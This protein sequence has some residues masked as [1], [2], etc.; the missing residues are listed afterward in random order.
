V[1]DESD[2]LHAAMRRRH[3]A[4]EE[5]SQIQKRLDEFVELD[6]LQLRRGAELFGIAGRLAQLLRDEMDL[7]QR[8]TAFAMGMQE[9][10]VITN[11]E[12]NILMGLV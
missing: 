1:S 4:C 2:A 6:Y 7:N 11:D 8:L 10:G 5:F 9:A 12:V 3:Q